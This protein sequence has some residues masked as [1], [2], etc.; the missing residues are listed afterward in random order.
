MLGPPIGSPVGR[1][2]LERLCHCGEREGLSAVTTSTEP[3]VRRSADRRISLNL[4]QASLDALGAGTGDGSLFEALRWVFPMATPELGTVELTAVDLQPVGHW[5]AKASEPL[6]VR[7]LR[8][9]LRAGEY[10]D[11]CQLDAVPW[12]CDERAAATSADSPAHSVG[13][14]RGLYLGRPLVPRLQLVPRPGFRRAASARQLSWVL[15]PDIGSSV[16]FTGRARTLEVRFGG[17][18]RVSV[19]PS[20][21]AGILASDG[22]DDPAPF[23]LS[24]TNL[25]RLR[26]LGA[27]GGSHNRRFSPAALAAIDET[28]GIEDASWTDRVLRIADLACRDREPAQV[29]LVEELSSTSLHYRPYGDLLRRAIARG[30][31]RGYRDHLDT[32]PALAALSRET[33]TSED[34][35]VLLLLRRL[36][37]RLEAA[38]QAEITEIVRPGAAGGVVG[39]TDDRGTVAAIESLRM[40]TRYGP[41]GERRR[42]AN[43]LWL[44]GIHPNRRGEIC[45]LLTPE[46]EDLGLIR[47]AA[48]GARP[49]I[50][51][52]EA[53]DDGGGEPADLSVAAGL[54]PFVNHD[55]PT[56]ASIAARMLRQ[57]VPI[58]GAGRPM[59]ET[60]VADRVAD[61]HGVCR[62][63]GSGQVA[64]VGRNWL[65]IAPADGSER[66][67]IGFGPATPS[68]SAVDGSW[69]LLVKP[70][71]HVYGG[72]LLAMA[73][74]VVVDAGTPHLAQGRDCLVAYMPWH[75][76]NF[77]DA[78]VVSSAV[79]EAFTSWHFLRSREPLDLVRG[80][81]PTLIVPVGA[82]VESGDSLVAIKVGNRVRRTIR[83][84]VGATL[85]ALEVD[86]DEVVIELRV[87]RPLAVGDKLTNRH[88]AKGV[89][90]TIVPEAEMPRLPDGRHVEMILN[91]LG[92]IRRL[93]LSQL[94]ETHATLRAF[95][96]GQTATEIV[97]RRLAA[98]ETLAADLAGLGA[99]GGRL[100]LLD[101]DGAPVGRASG[102]VVGWQH[103]LKLDHLAASKER[104]RLLGARSPVSQ[105]PAKGATWVAGSLVGG[106]QRLGEMELWALQAV[107]AD[108][109]VRDAHDRSDR[110]Y[111][112]IEAVAAHLRV[113][114][115][116]VRRNEAGGPSVERDL[117]ATGLRD[118]P[119]DLVTAIELPRLTS[120]EGSPILDPLHDHH[121]GLDEESRCPCG[122]ATAVGAVC[123]V[124][125]SRTRLHPGADRR[126]FAYRI[127]LATPVRHP[128]ASDDSSWDLRSIPLLPPA[129]RPYAENRL[130]H[131]Y[132]RLII[133]NA[134][135][136]GDPK[137]GR[138]R[139]EAAVGELLGSVDDPPSAETIAARLNGKRGLLRRALRGRDT[140]YAARG[141]MVPE[142][143][144][145]PETIGI[146]AGAARVLG[147]DQIDGDQIVL[148][149]RQPTL[150]PTNLVALRAEVAE[151]S[152]FRIHPFLCARLAGDFDGDEITVHRPVTAHASQQAWSLLRPAAS[153]RHIANDL[154]MSKMD[155]DVALGLWL[156][157]RD[158]GGRAALAE[159]LG[160]ALD[161]PLA[162]ST[163]PISA[164]EKDQ[165]VRRLA[166]DAATGR[167]A[168]QA[169]CAVF[170]AGAHAATGWS[171]S[172]LEL[173][174]VAKAMHQSGL[175]V[176]PPDSALGEAVA[177]GQAG[178][179][180][181]IAQLLARR[182]SLEGFD[183]LPTPAVE[184]SF[185]T[186]LDDADYFATTPG[187]LRALSDKKLVTPL[188]GGLTKSLIEAAYDVVVVEHDCGSRRAG[189]GAVLT[190]QTI[191]GVCTR[192]YRSAGGEPAAPGVRV[193]LLAAFAI[194]ERST[195]NA[196]K[197]FQGGTT[198]AVGGNVRRLRALFGDGRIVRDGA[199]ETT[200]SKIMAEPM[201]SSERLVAPYVSLR[202]QVDECLD[203]LVGAHHL[204][205][206]WRRLRAVHQAG[207][208]R[209]LAAAQWP[210]SA[211]V[212]ST[213]RGDL[214]A[215]VESVDADVSPDR[216][217]S[218]LR[219]A[220]IQR[221]L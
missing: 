82:R 127:R 204:E 4:H 134:R 164:D 114:G 139:L 6:W 123:P 177:A 19:E 116:R 61:E 210:G 59:L 219:L 85:T 71:D 153:Y 202:S 174:D 98:V 211:F 145:D 169:M 214:S 12:L 94:L 126:S 149:N 171:F 45:P 119:A 161:D 58:R 144:R 15:V 35:H 17:G 151:G 192:C 2:L 104:A 33:A 110:E 1:D 55:D 38:A 20:R 166:D 212:H 5:H 146:P 102:V 75:G 78:I 27:D 50:G 117:D 188:A 69:R 13:G 73:P 206:V 208:S 141:V 107:S 209:P 81:L 163:G 60:A 173:L 34:T 95:L 24:G 148:V 213:T 23:G 160:L 180:K 118:L 138:L 115:L 79:C 22:R 68:P 62:A 198:L 31:L 89:V 39:M 67:V 49:T 106:A 76:Q 99:P 136:A 137:R 83:A 122:G 147:L 131:A 25:R 124:C 14:H 168:V 221:S 112:S 176:V 41:A 185:L 97:G 130:D 193:G 30:A 51:G 93:N 199:E 42:G 47:S 170:A 63:G 157:G 54:I 90:S 165:L 43:R 135:S 11:Y 88:G 37:G 26:G 175:D 129:F 101:P 207:S 57:S 8:F 216:T 156:T 87:D 133:E 28:L 77:E 191:D 74:D 220:V 167:Q 181:G 140:D 189:F 32:E 105:Q 40:I 162:T 111:E 92:V 86:Q 16:T 200:L 91:P 56:R 125:H 196:M 197:A 103:I 52:L 154:P 113:G 53:S 217:A 46:S 187:G 195:Q 21:L 29:R 10:A 203:N 108:L 72:D 186:G 84:A 143:T 66:V 70:G 183:G 132:R 215:L 36:A 194:G 64:G 150:L 18:E 3:A 142:P 109:L 182:G 178:K 155:L 48:L 190:C 159:R 9:F 121:H 7:P 80:E 184:T 172:A 100:P 158:P 96:R 120:G 205:V 152:A 44:R 201:T 65:E 218:R 128:W 179:P